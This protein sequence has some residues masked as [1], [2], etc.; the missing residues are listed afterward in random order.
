MKPPLSLCLSFSLMFEVVLL[1]IKSSLADDELCSV[2]EELREFKGEV[3]KLAESIK[4]L[5][6]MKSGPTSSFQVEG[7][8]V[9]AIKFFFYNKCTGVKYINVDGMFVLILMECVVL[10]FFSNYFR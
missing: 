4:N 9:K 5:Q 8:N 3:T 7:S 10:I 2:R 1:I 6:N